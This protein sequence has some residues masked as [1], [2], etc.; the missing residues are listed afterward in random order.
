MPPDRREVIPSAVQEG[1]CFLANHEGI[2][3]T[4]S[5]ARTVRLYGP[6]HVEAMAQSLQHIVNRHEALRTVF[7]ERDGQYRAAVL[8]TLSAPLPRVDLCHLPAETALAEAEARSLTEIRRPFDLAQGPLLRFLLFRLQSEDHLLLLNF[9]HTV[10]D[11]STVTTFRRELAVCYRAFSTGDDPA[12]PPL[13]LQYADAAQRQRARLTPER[14]EELWNYWRGALEGA[15]ALLELPTDARRP[16]QQTFDSGNVSIPLPADLLQGLRALRS[17]E[18]VSLFVTF[19]SA[20][21]ILLMRLS[22]QEDV[23]VGVSHVDREDRDTLPLIGCLVNMLPIRATTA[24]NPGFRQFLHQV[25]TTLKA[26]ITHHALPFQ[27]L[28]KRR[29]PQRHAAYPPVFQASI[30]L[31]HEET[32]GLALPGL[33]Q[34]YRILPAEGTAYDLTLFVD[35][36]RTE[37]HCRF[38]YNR[39]LFTE[40]TLQRAAGHFR[41]LL[42]GLVA[43]PDQPVEDLPLLAPAERQQLLVDWNT[44]D[45]PYPASCVHHLFE[46]QVKRT[47]GAVAVECEGKRLTYQ[48]LNRKA[49]ELAARLQDLGVGP[50]SM[51]AICVERSPQMVI[52]VLGIL[53][54]GGVYVPLDPSYPKERLAFMLEDTRAPVLLTQQRLVTRLPSPAAATVLRL[55]TDEAFSAGSTPVSLSALVT[56]ESLAYVIYTS[57][58][59]GHPK[60]VAIPHRAVSRLVLNTDYISLGP[61]DVVAQAASFSFDAATFEIWGALLH[62]ATLVILPEAVI[63]SPEQLA[64]RLKARGITTLFLTTA[65]FNLVARQVPTAFSPLTTVLFGG[66]AVDPHW[67]RVILLQGPPRRLLHVYGPTETT[68]FATWH[69]VEAVAS[70]TTPVPI[71]RPIANTHAFILDAHRQPVPIGVGGELYLGGPGLARGYLNRPDLTAERFVAHPFSPDASERLY[72][73]GDVARFMADGSIE[74]IGRRDGQVKIRG[75]RIELGEI[76][77]ALM[78]TGGIRQAA[79]VAEDDG[80]G[81]RRLVAYCM[82][83]DAA[84]ITPATVRADLRRALPAYMV[85]QVVLVDA[86]PLTPN[87]K[88]DRAAL[89]ACGGITA[90][91]PATALEAPR[92]TRELVLAELFRDLLRRDD[93]GIHDDFFE[94]GGHSLM[95]M[96]LIARIHQLT[97]IRLSA[98]ALFDHPTVAGLASAM[99]HLESG[100]AATSFDTPRWSHLVPIKEGAREPL[101]FAVGGDG[102]EGAILVYARLARYLAPDRPFYSFK[103]AGMDGGGETPHA[104]VEAMATDYVRELRE[105]QPSGP[106]SLAGG[107]IGGVIAYEM[108]R[109]LA[110]SGETVR[111]LILLDTPYPSPRS[112]GRSLIRG[113]CSHIRFGVLLSLFGG[114]F[115]RELARRLQEE[116]PAARIPS[117]LARGKGSARLSLRRVARHALIRLFGHR[118]ES[119]PAPGPTGFYDS[120][121]AIGPRR[122]RFYRQALR[123]LP[124]SHAQADPGL[125]SAWIRYANTLHRYRPKSYHGRVDLLICE[126]VA[127]TSATQ[128]WRALVG[129]RLLVHTVP[130]THDNYIRS[131]I[132]RTGT[133]LNQILEEPA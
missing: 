23:I 58:S 19:L 105:V 75:Y 46:D 65:L 2:G 67:V 81:E 84:K 38:E 128:E 112:Y 34:D 55:D 3:S 31:L 132:D 108:A 77:H 73:T 93:I 1:F 71:G 130:G 4:H 70:D 30:R 51:V 104:S 118:H 52:G 82:A 20:F 99:T 54:A 18:D 36:S 57:G 106:Y 33:Q 87:G 94:Y 131:G 95:A 89:R 63:V 47:P 9:H 60:G 97:G 74:F 21:Q 126:E 16:P 26:A 119:I 78:Q 72:R 98:R 92:N 45:R 86:L 32:E 29:V 83:K 48:A 68:T 28:V 14:T 50:E 96:R 107:C 101:F 41:Q 129:P 76:E 27:K 24:G 66:E 64:G 42:E 90:P 117:G 12:L 35:V 40:A 85:P 5:V 111:R 91:A 122:Y 113:A 103:E 123:W 11:A 56:G 120:L 133:L 114:A 110:A 37:G 15:P 8:S 125:L 43:I 7:Y 59:T 25:Q 109:Q 80:H 115:A 22:G 100:G 39:A 53:K 121:P 127:A 49:D 10:I 69:R 124:Y 62:G 61:T 116:Q 17:A 44:T 88:L 13:T 79:A 102:A 6:L